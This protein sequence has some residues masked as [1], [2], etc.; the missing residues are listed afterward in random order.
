MDG[1]VKGEAYREI[2][3]ALEA[4]TMQAGGASVIDLAEPPPYPVPSTVPPPI[5][6]HLARNAILGVIL[7]GMAA[8]VLVF[9]LEVASDRVRSPT[10]MEQWFGLVSMGVVP[11]GTKKGP[12]TERLGY[13]GHSDRRSKEAFER[14]ATNLEFATAAHGVRSLLVSSP[15]SWNGRTTLVANLG[16]AMARGG[17]SVVLLDADLRYPSSSPIFRGERR[18]GA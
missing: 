15:S 12:P 11:A 4:S 5:Q 14:V 2:A 1:L 8:L 10:Q 16:A 7:A 17:K 13:A 3:G 18:P 6:T 9:L